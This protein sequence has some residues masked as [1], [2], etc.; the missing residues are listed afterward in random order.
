MMKRNTL[1]VLLTAILLLCFR[2]SATA[3]TDVTSL[4]LSNAG[5]D[6]DADFVSSVVYTYAKDANEHGG[7]SSCQ[8][9]TAWTADATGDAK[10]G[11]AFAF[12]S[13]CG[14][15]GT[16]YV[17]PATDADGNSAGGALGL[18]ACW[19][20]S[21]GYSQSVSLPKGFYR[22]SFQVYN[23]GDNTQANYTSA[24]GFI[25]DDG[26]SHY[27]ETDFPGGEWTEAVVYLNLPTA[28]SGNIHLGY[29]CANVG[30]AA[31]PK[32]FVDYVKIEQLPL[33]YTIGDVNDDS[34]IT[35]ADVTALVNIILG[36]TE[37]KAV[38]LS[39]TYADLDAM[40]F[41]QQSAAET[42]SGPDY[43]LDTAVCSL[44]GDDV[45]A[46]YHMADH[47]TTLHITTSLTNVASV[48]V[49]ALGKENI[50]G[51]MTISCQGH[52]LSYGYPAG[53]ASTYANSLQSDVVSVVADNADTY[54]AYLRPVS[55][56]RGVKVTVRTTDGRYYSQDF[57]SIVAGQT[58]TLAFTA[59]AAQN[60]WQSTIPGNTYFSMLSTPGAH[61]AATSS[62]S[63]STAKC[64][65]E[66]LAGLLANG[67][68]AFDLRPRYTSN[69]QSDILLDNLTIY[70]GIV[71]TGI[72][73]KDAIDI[74]IDF[75]K[76]NPSE[77]VSVI[78]NKENS[79]GLFSQTDQ[80]ET[81][82]ASI[83]EC[84]GD[85]ARSPYLMGS[86]RGY[87]TLDDVRGKVS[88][89]SRNPYGNSNN[90]YRDVVYG[91][92][93]ENWP[94]NGVITDYSCD[95]TQAW[96]WVDCRASVEDAYN[97]NT[98]T[99]QSQVQAQLQLASSN[100]DHFHYCYTYTSI[101]NNP[102]SYAATMNPATVSIIN[103]LSGPLCYVYADYMG[104]Q[105]NGGAALLSAIIAQNYKYVFSGR[106]RVE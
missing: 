99:K 71:S 70:H 58:N 83:R 44:T 51:P 91:A 105:S 49:Y 29:S 20:N 41:A 48:S 75:V 93:I 31:T 102:A 16:T 54:T 56:P 53:D 36:K 104:S 52:E 33:S 96:N 86:V 59:T 18:A 5:F 87:H 98:S 8:P 89:V 25:S 94:D 4:Y 45:S 62:V 76:N 90:S 38:D 73:F 37:A 68:R 12:G 11:G 13:G 60:L 81:W 42:A 32:L 30:S 43:I 92:I 35:I 79:S 82:R 1:T 34:A 40:V 69:T 66:D 65:S 100:T 9:V 84:F 6:V 46:H 23:A 63:V 14:L 55:L 15:S 47:L 22:L 26:T 88:V 2:L 61:D 3:Q 77:A 57:P 7:V 28:T 74:L 106:S 19:T 27:A 67:V 39:W 21:V 101:A 10:A 78:M 64:Q 50:A 85:P 97:S 17:V 72:K 80:S 24:I 103:T 95:M